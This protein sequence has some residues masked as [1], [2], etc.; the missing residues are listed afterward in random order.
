MMETQCCFTEGQWHGLPL[1]NMAFAVLQEEL[2]KEIVVLE[3]FLGSEDASHEKRRQR[4]HSI[5]GPH[6]DVRMH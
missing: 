5:D 4:K 1:K 2:E 6:A 3:W